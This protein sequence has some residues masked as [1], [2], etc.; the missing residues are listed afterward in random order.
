MLGSR[1]EDNESRMGKYIAYSGSSV[2]VNECVE[3][4]GAISI[5]EEEAI[6]TKTSVGEGWK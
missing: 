3:R 6:N 4:E 2:I 5:C 1:L